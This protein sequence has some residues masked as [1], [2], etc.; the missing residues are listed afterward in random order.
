MVALLLISHP[1]AG[2]PSVATRWLASV[3]QAGGGVKIR[4]VRRWPSVPQRFKSAQAAKSVSLLDVS[5]IPPLETRSQTLDANFSLSELIASQGGQD[6][7]LLAVFDT[8]AQRLN[9]ARTTQ[10][11][12][13]WLATLANALMS[14]A[15]PSPL[16]T[17][18]GAASGLLDGTSS[19]VIA[20]APRRTWKLT[21]ARVRRRFMT[22]KSS[23]DIMRASVVGPGVHLSRGLTADWGSWLSPFKAWRVSQTSQLANGDVDTHCLWDT[24]PFHRM[25]WP[26]VS[27]LDRMCEVPHPAVSGFHGWTQAGV[28]PWQMMTVRGC[29]EGRHDYRR[30]EAQFHVTFSRP[31][32]QVLRGLVAYTPFEFL[33]GSI[34][35]RHSPFK[36]L[37]GSINTRHKGKT[38]P[39][40]TTYPGRSTFSRPGV[41]VCS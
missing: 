9:A 11:S 39:R 29:T 19:S 13:V 38:T 7:L 1:P 24:C 12:Q 8:R 22:D 21:F 20:H 23:Y 16:V 15:L 35:T 31:G 10:T 28:L 3:S 37:V 6:S 14:M 33:V 2:R 41:D 34:N 18:V 32:G 17:G 36:F 4:A 25:S 5:G 30:P 26:G 40:V 27:V